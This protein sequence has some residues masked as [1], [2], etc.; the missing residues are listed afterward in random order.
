MGERAEHVDELEI[1][2]RL[3]VVL[4]N[5]APVVFHSADELVELEHHEATVGTELH[6]VALDLLGDPAHHLG[7]LQHGG[8]VAD[9]DEVFHLECGQRTA[10]RVET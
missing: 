2:R 8:D 10:H 7:A 6:H 1:V 9:G 5:Q 4:G 3:E